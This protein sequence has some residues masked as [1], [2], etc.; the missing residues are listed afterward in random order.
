MCVFSGDVSGS[1]TCQDLQLRDEYAFLDCDGDL[2]DDI[3][4]E[5]DGR[6]YCVDTMTGLR[7]NDVVVMEANRSTLDCE[8]RLDCS[9]SYATYGY[10]LYCCSIATQLHTHT[11]VETGSAYTDVDDPLYYPGQT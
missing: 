9:S 8:G 4:C 10:F 6:C 5:P 11:R 1:P 3:Q 7:L 2:F